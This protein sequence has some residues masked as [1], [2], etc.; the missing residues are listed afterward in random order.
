M[1]EDIT[2]KE[3][4]FLDKAETWKV[5]QIKNYDVVS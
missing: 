4:D 5:E 2:K 3:Q 1:H